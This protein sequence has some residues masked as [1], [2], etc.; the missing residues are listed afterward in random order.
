MFR[1]LTTDINLCWYADFQSVVETAEKHQKNGMREIYKGRQ[2]DKS[3]IRQNR[4][5]RNK[6]CMREEWHHKPMGG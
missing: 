5:L 3:S 2:T 4:K 1:F 6:P